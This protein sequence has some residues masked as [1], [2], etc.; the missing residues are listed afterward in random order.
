LNALATRHLRNGRM[1]EALAVFEIMPE[2]SPILERLGQPG[3]AH[4]NRDDWDK[5]EEFYKKS[6]ELNPRTRTAGTS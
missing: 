5:A 4:L 2:P 3:E 1:A 6:V